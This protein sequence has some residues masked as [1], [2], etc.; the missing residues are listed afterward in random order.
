MTADYAL[1][2]TER[3]ALL[4]PQRDVEAID[5]LDTAG[6]SGAGAAGERQAGM[7]GYPQLLA[8]ADDLVAGPVVPASARVVTRLRGCAAGWCWQA[9][10]VLLRRSFRVHDIPPVLQGEHSGLLAGFVDL[11]PGLAFVTD[12]QRLGRC[13]LPAQIAH[14]A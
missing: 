14:A 8:L 2:R 13:A 7:P 12:A 3:F 6:L 10:D 5:Y 4:L 11:G 9:A 1:L